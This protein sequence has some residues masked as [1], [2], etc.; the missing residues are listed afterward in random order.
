MIKDRLVTGAAAGIAGALAQNAY[1]YIARFL[2]WRGPVYEDYG[3]ILLFYR[4]HKGV[5]PTVLGLLG[6]FVWDIIIAILFAYLIRQ[7]SSRYYLLKGTLYGMI[8]WFFI[9]AGSTLFKIPVII[10]VMPGTVAF[11]FAGSVIY[12]LA[13][14]LCLRWLD[15]SPAPI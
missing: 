13:I 1:A 3:Q 5:L 12:G 9:K 11:F 6:H 7:T 8:V 15:R 10:N 2:G 14:T 4:I